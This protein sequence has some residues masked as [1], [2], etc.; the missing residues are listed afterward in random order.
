MRFII[1]A[2]L[3]KDLSV[4]SPSR[5]SKDFCISK[6]YDNSPPSERPKCPGIMQ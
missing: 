6:Q 2:V 5:P 3:R 1:T 4:G